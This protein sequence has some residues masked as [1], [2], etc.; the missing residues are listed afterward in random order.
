MDLYE[1][2]RH[3]PSCRYFT[4]DPVEPE[5]MHRVLDNARFAS[6]GGNR[7][8]WRVVVVADPDLRAGL[9]ELHRRQWEPYLEHAK[10]GVVGY[11]GDQS[12]QRMEAG[13][14]YAT[15]RLNRT[16]DFSTQLQDVPI[17]LVFYVQLA[18]LAIT[19]SD[20]DRPSIVGGGSI[21]PFLQNVL[22]GCTAEGLG[23]A[24]T[25]L[26]AAEQPEVDE[27]LGVEPG[28]ALAALV[29]VGWPVRDKLYRRLTRNPVEDFAFADRWGT[30]FGLS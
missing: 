20:L 8:G 15:R 4:P 30:S 14:D 21:Y 9:A 23:S 27:L 10:E 12:G 2:M 22:L 1:A 5:I 11:Q 29:A 7:Q 18:T 16:D 28:M 3:T 19:D 26:L 17:L 25:T 6:S 24:L 13:T